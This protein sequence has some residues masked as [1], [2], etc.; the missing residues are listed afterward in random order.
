[1]NGNRLQLDRLHHRQ[2]R[3]GQWCSGIRPRRDRRRGRNTVEVVSINPT[4]LNNVFKIIEA[5][6]GLTGKEFLAIQEVY[7]RGE[8]LSK[9]L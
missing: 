3:A 5:Q 9:C 8:P 7:L 4:S 2:M 6:A 1:M